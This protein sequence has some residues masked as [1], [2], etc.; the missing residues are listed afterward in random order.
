MDS[1]F[2]S[3]EWTHD[4]ASFSPNPCDS[5]IVK[6]KLTFEGGRRIVAQPVS[7]K[8]PMTSEILGKIV[9]FYETE[10]SLKGMRICTMCILGFSGFLRFNEIASLR[11]KDVQ[12]H[13]DFISICISRSK[14]DQLNKG[15]NIEIARTNNK[16]CPL[17]WLTRYVDMAGLTCSSNEYTLEF[18][19]VRKEVITF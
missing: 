14:T 11:M 8:E 13:N 10:N 9:D 5:R 7:K 6:F 1:Y 2:Y 12:F 18:D 15:T 19:S 4:F 17:S 16:L 3:I